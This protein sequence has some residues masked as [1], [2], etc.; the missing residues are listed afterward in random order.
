M[1]PSRRGVLGAGLFSVALTIPEWQHVVGRVEAVQSGRRDD[2]MR[3]MRA[4]IRP[5]L[6]HPDARALYERSRTLH[7]TRRV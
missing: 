3:N 5:H 2:R 7:D 4:L 1:D 6:A